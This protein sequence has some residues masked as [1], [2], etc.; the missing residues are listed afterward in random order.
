MNKLNL[1]KSVL[2]ILVV[3]LLFP[4][5]SKYEEGPSF[6]LKSSK[7]RVVNE[8]IIEYAYDFDDAIEETEKYAGETWEFLKDGDFIE[9]ENGAIDK[10]G[11]WELIGDNKSLKISLP[12]D[13][14]YYDIIKLKENEMW[15]KD[16]D[17]ELH[18]IP[19]N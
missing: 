17:D 15:L 10:A 6:S 11:T 16:N 4:S 13:I 5:C 1:C 18:L 9:R 7:T 12:G 19:K 2:L 8:W 14:D 3:P